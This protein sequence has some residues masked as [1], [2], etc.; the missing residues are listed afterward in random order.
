MTKGGARAAYPLGPLALREKARVRV[1]F[2]QAYL[3]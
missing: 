1:G 2:Q 3:N